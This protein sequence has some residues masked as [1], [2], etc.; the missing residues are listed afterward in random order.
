[1]MPSTTE[2]MASVSEMTGLRSAR[3]SPLSTTILASFSSN[4]K[5]SIKLH[6]MSTASFFFLV[7]LLR[8]LLANGG[9]DDGGGGVPVGDLPRSE[10]RRP[11]STLGGGAGST[12]S[13]FRFRRNV[14]TM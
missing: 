1:M 13:P 6:S 9:G 3:D 12:C 5:V 8:E 4:S 10:E 7:E 14:A 11:G 2:I